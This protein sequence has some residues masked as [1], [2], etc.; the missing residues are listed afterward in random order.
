[1]GQN[2]FGEIIC[3]YPVVEDELFKARRKGEVSTDYPTEQPLVRQAVQTTLTDV[4]L[5]GG[6]EKGQS[7]RRACLQKPSLKLDVQIFRNS[8]AAVSSRCD[9]VAVL[10]EGDRVLYRYHLVRRRSAGSA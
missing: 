7:A 4:A 1:V 2:A 10:Y 8:V 9:C 3:F 6:I 5:T